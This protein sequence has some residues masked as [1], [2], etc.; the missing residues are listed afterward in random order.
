VEKSQYELCTAVLRRLDGV[1]VLKHIVLVGSWCTVLYRDYFASPA[2]TP[3]LRTRDI[4]LLL[5]RPSAIT[6]R[7]DVADL[8]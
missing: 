4:D 7:T 1:G 3:S 6:S 2:Y 8:L 5:P